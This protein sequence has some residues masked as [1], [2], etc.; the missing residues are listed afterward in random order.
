MTGMPAIRAAAMI[1]TQ[2]SSTGRIAAFRAGS[3]GTS[4]RRQTS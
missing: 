4:A 3:D 1:F 2:A